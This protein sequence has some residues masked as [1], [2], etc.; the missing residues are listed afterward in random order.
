[1]PEWMVNVPLRRGEEE[2][3][4]FERSP[5]R[6]MFPCACG[7]SGAW[8]GGTYS[9]TE[10]SA[11]GETGIV[12]ERDGYPIIR[13]ALIRARRRGDVDTVA[14]LCPFGPAPGCII[15]HGLPPGLRISH[16]RAFTA[17]VSYW[18][19][20]FDPDTLKRPIRATVCHE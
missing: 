15:G 4:T 16:C 10:L 7:T 3:P 13:V 1:M 6:C 20:V 18:I 14:F 9:E 19:E 5:V 11:L 8:P 17:P 2:R 12:G